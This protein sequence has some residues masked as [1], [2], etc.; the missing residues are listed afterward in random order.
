MYILWSD[1][2]V[3]SI[4]RRDYG[5]AAEGKD[6]Q[7]KESAASEWQTQAKDRETGCY[8]PVV[9]GAGLE[10]ARRED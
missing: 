10:A 3:T 1:I 5:E 7:T 6:G 4:E 8:E 9:C 2:L